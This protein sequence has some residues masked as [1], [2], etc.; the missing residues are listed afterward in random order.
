LAGGIG[1]LTSAQNVYSVWE[2]LKDPGPVHYNGHIVVGGIVQLFIVAQV[3]FL[4]QSR[5][6]QSKSR[7]LG[8]V[9]LLW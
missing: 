2:L 4:I 5:E 9:M 3:A 7:E 1:T 6:L 8:H